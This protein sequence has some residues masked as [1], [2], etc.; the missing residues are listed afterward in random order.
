MIK[1]YQ[2]EEYYIKYTCRKNIKTTASLTASLTASKQQFDDKY[3]G[4]EW[5]FNGKLLAITDIER[6]SEY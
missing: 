6:K 2:N 3:A 4:S 5:Q 1:T